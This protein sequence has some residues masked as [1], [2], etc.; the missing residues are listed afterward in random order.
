MNDD[1]MDILG[2]WKLTACLQDEVHLTSDRIGM[3]FRFTEEHRTILELGIQSEY[4][5]LPNRSPKAINIYVSRSDKFY[6]RGIYELEADCLRILLNTDTR[7]SRPGSMEGIKGDQY[8]AV[9][10]FHR[11]S[12]D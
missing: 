3:T 12:K 2:D 5:L 9:E 8:K 11:I 10:V 1:R 6:F 4:D 7:S